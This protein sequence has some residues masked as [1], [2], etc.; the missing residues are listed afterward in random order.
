MNV[1][2]THIHIWD[3]SKVRYS[4]L[5]GNTS[6][7]NRNYL[8]GELEPARLVAG[9]T[10][11]VLVQAANNTEEADYMLRVAAA[12]PWLKGVVGW[13]PLTD[14]V[15]TERLLKEQYGLNPLFKG[16]RHLIHDEAD[17]RW[18]LQP[19]VIES[20]G[21]LAR[22]GISYDVVGVKPEHIE[23]ALAVA[24]RVPTL[25]MIFD[26]CCQPPIATGERFGR[27]GELMNAAAA[28][29]PFHVKVS[30]LG[31]TAQKE[32]D[33]TADDIAPYVAFVLEH[34]GVSRVCCGG[35]WP[36]CL[37]AGSYADAWRNYKEVLTSLLDRS[38]LEKV[39][40]T[41]ALSYYRLQ[42]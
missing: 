27:W 33:W 9:V 17:V 34:F 12:H 35:D 7:L 10:G 42:P 18:L 6:I 29:L 31:I 14:P 13:L 24:E 5:E 40:Y 22:H 21:I 39:F 16:V 20:L 32:A 28:H 41:N 30:G 25:S 19:T 37:M 26:H 8:L 11:G 36:V 3:L 38:S 4:W 23:T 15:L 1:I 2:D